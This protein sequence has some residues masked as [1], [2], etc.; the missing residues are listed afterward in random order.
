MNAAVVLAAGKGTRLRSS[1]PKVLHRV[2]GRPLL[3][4]VLEALRPL[5]CDAVVVVVGHG[6]QEV[7]A[8]ADTLGITGLTCVTQA[9]QLGTGHAV[10]VALESGHLA[11]AG[12]VLVVAGD[13]PALTTD[14]LRRLSAE[15]GSASA[16]V[17]TTRLQDPRGYGRIIRVGERITG[18]VEQADADESQLAIDEVNTGLFAFDATSLARALGQITTDNAQ[19][20]EY[21]TD[22]VALL[23]AQ[24][25]VRGVEVDGDDV[26]GVNDREQLAQVEQLLR[27]RILGQLMRDGV[28]IIDPDSTY[29]E[30]DVMVQPDACLLPGVLL[31]GH[32]RIA[33]NATVGPYSQ[34][35]DTVVESGATVAF[36]VATQAHIGR[37]AAV[38]PYTHL[39]PGTVLHAGSKAGGFVEMK[40]A[41]I[42]EGSKVPHL[43]YV[44]DAR[45]G[46][47]VNFGAGSI[48]VNYDGFDKFTTTIAD[49][50]FIGSD[51]ML[52]A[53]VDI[54]AGA[55]V[56]AGST[57]TTD[58]PA[59]ALAVERAERRTIE[60]WAARK[61]DRHAA[62][63][64]AASDPSQANPDQPT[65]EQ[66][67]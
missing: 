26:R 53:P 63:T 62:R 49:G 56:G 64:D 42:G 59:D 57:I 51:S 60:G 4:W 32:T 25:T 38:G 2:A 5:D 21:L 7:A 19:G 12:E 65:N 44:G 15:R 31:H 9:Q 55:F 3:G 36:T 48:T 46:Q 30:V 23:A 52:V 16:A 8:Y 11:T 1:V 39:R 54:G 18:I 17:L 45:L 41:V 27:G 37:D 33:E 66:G 50:A 35:T 61:R 14:S 24:D 40:N 43:S 28:R 10:R 47:G 20:E 22:T 6:G 58:V 13:V 34:L 67:E 29:V